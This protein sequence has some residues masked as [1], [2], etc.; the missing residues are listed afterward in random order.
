MTKSDARYYKED[1]RLDKNISQCKG[2]NHIYHY[3]DPPER[4]PNADAKCNA[5][6]LK[7]NVQMFPNEKD[8]DTFTGGAKRSAAA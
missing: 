4:P 6:M 1:F 3:A 7:S 2:G 8:K 5:K